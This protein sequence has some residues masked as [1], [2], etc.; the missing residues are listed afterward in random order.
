GEVI[1]VPDLTVNGVAA[2]GREGEAS[3]VLRS[4]VGVIGGQPCRARGET[5]VEALAIH[6]RRVGWV[7]QCHAYG[8]TLED[9]SGIAQA[10]GLGRRVVDG[11]RSGGGGDGV[12]G[13]IVVLDLYLDR[14][15]GGAV[16]DTESVELR[17]GQRGIDAGG[18][19]EAAVAIEVPTVG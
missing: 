4:G 15:L 9:R 3:C 1:F 12:S 19:A 6:R 17:P 7:R 8:A 10:V 2:A 13:A 18:V 16:I 11:E 14:E 5:K